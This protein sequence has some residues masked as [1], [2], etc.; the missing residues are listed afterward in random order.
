[1]YRLAAIDL[2]GTLLTPEKKISPR[3][4]GAIKA[5]RANGLRV[6]LATARP[7]YRITKYLGLLGLTDED[8]YVISFNGGL[9]MRADGQEQIYRHF[10][11]AGEVGEVV[12]YARSIEVP[13]FVY[14]E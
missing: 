14:L 6:V 4:I 7:F 1:M 5:W 12:S 2:D 3:S 10:F 13:T 11:T 9:V 8:D